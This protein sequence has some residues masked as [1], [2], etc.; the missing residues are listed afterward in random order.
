M[1]TVLVSWAFP[2]SR[3]PRSVQ[4]GRL[5]AH[6]SRLEPEVVCSAEGEQDP[7]VLAVLGGRHVPV[8]SVPTPAWTRALRR[9]AARLRLLAPDAEVFW[10]RAATAAVCR[11]GLREDEALVTF[12][13]PMSDH[14]VG[15]GVPRPRGTPWIAHFSDPWT[16]NPY[17]SPPPGPIH[18]RAVELERRVMS[19]ADR[20]VFTAEETRDLVMAK[21]PESW[22]ERTRIL[23]HAFDR[24]L[25]PPPACAPSGQLVVRYLGALYGPRSQRP[26]VEA[27]AALHARS[28]AVLEGVRFEFVGSTEEPVESAARAAGLP[29]GIVTAR[30]RVDYGT[31]LA[32][33]RSAD[34]LL[35]LDAPAQ[36]SVFLP[37]KLIE[38]LGADRP[39]LAITP[40]GPA[41]RLVEKCGG[42]TVG[43]GD[44]IAIADTL[45]GALDA[46]RGGR[47]WDPHPAVKRFS[48]P[49]VTE[50]FEDIVI[51]A[52]RA[53]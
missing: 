13:N 48:A 39:V 2:P 41:Q 25:D 12:G 27:L 22:R 40:P 38:Y 11:R 46:L 15:L 3:Y 4:V 24:A 14:L 42:W 19:G 17:Y 49:H 37:S 26:L 6:L 28:P 52:A 36:R 51:E 45:A 23:P 30:G 53:G 20:L 16:D 5:V 7:S 21:F 47:A 29:A 18:R 33:M 50:Q 9:P 44:P 35:V 34:L 10:A 8:Q 31:S 43:P 32:L 1:K